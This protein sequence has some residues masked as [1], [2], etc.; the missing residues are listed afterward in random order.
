MKVTKSGVAKHISDALQDH[1]PPM[2]ISELAK[3]TGITLSKLKR[4]VSGATDENGNKRL[5]NTDDLFIIAK[6][7]DIT[8]YRLMTG[9]SDENHVVCEELG[10]SSETVDI[11]RMWN[12]VDSS[13]TGK[14]Y[15]QNVIDILVANPELL[16]AIGNYLENDFESIVFCD[17]G[18][19]KKKF[20]SLKLSENTSI[21]PDD[22]ERMARLRL[23]D[24]LKQVR[25][26]IKGGKNK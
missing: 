12:K 7:L 21:T 19:K 16:Y 6:A 2:T 3:R 4:L 20:T 23:L 24:G 10:L 25:S 14:I 5:P 13:G 17:Y 9:I 22:Y 15:A 1:E 18:E 26:S 11:L 8:P